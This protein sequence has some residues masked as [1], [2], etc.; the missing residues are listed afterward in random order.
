MLVD[1][2]N[3]T[4]TLKISIRIKDTKAPGFYIFN[5]YTNLYNDDGDT[6][7]DDD[8]NDDDDDY[9]D[10]YGDDYGDDIMKAPVTL[11]SRKT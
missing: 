5:S 10:D 3:L 8:D 2:I 1:K 7:D 6:Y 4:E 11:A 9:F